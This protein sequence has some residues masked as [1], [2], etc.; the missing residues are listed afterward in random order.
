MHIF[1]N[2]NNMNI[3][4]T[5]QIIGPQATAHSLSPKSDYSYEL[6]SLSS[7]QAVQA[8]ATLNYSFNLSSIAFLTHFS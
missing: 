3:Y 8:Q 4:G 6:G 1:K 2:L 7:I 5:H